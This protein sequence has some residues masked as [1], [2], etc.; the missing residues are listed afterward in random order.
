M[1]FSRIDYSRRFLGIGYRTRFCSAFLGVGI[2]LEHGGTSAAVST[3]SCDAL[4]SCSPAECSVS[5]DADC[6]FNTQAPPWS[7]AIRDELPCKTCTV[8]TN[9][10]CAS[11]LAAAKTSHAGSSIQA[12][13]CND[14]YLV[15]AASGLPLGYDPGQSTGDQYLKA[16]PLP[17][18]GNGG[19]RVRSA[20]AQL[21]VFKIPLSSTPLAAGAAN[22]VT[23]PLPNVPGM[24]AAGAVAVAIDG[25]PMFPNYNN[26]GK[27]TWTS[28]E[29]DRCNAHSGKGED[30]HYHGDFFGAKCLY[31]ESDYGSDVGTGHP[32]LIGWALDGYEVFG[33]YTRSTQQGQGVARDSCGGHEHA[34][35]S[36]YHYHPEVDTSMTTNSLDGTN[37]G[38]ATVTYT[39]YKLAPMECWKGNVGLIPNFW[40]ANGKQALYDSTKLGTLTGRADV[41]QLKPCCT[42]QSS[43]YYLRS[44]LQFSGLTAG[45][46]NLQC[47]G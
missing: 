13:Y 4:T 29:V 17:P 32:P 44:G 11:A 6:T 26:R 5:T 14:E 20:A 33:R 42:M 23:N 2:L 3:A 46:D 30:Y 36:A 24:P 28:C 47:T 9:S 43:E 19:C 27:F 15:I 35:V 31:T 21:N 37:L 25:V 8:S 1:F 18:G 12:V 34:G 45:V 41:E 40:T 22:T 16:M 39:A 10:K 38:G 7:T